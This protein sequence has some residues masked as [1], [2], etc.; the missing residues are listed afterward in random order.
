MMIIFKC[1]IILNNIEV[2]DYNNINNFHEQEELR[3]KN[4]WDI[5]NNF[6]VFFKK[7]AKRKQWKHADWAS[8][9]G[10]DDSF[11]VRVGRVEPLRWR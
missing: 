6:S 7:R 11:R 9:R 5:I 3:G 10:L 8:C 4:A 1:R 2:R